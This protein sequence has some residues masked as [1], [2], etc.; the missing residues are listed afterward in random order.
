MNRAKGLLAAGT[1]TGVI[2]ITVLVFG[3]GSL[4]AQPDDAQANPDTAAPAVVLP[5]DATTAT[6]TQANAQELQD[7][8]AY[9]Q[10][11]EAALQIMQEREAVYQAQIEQ[12]N[13]TVLQLQDQLNA[14]MQMQPSIIV[15]QAAPGSAVNNHERSEHESHEGF[16]FDDD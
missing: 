15:G 12:A 7:L 16:E 11:L 5:A 1:L 13:R 4:K 9:N 6:T 14:Q 8:R 3:F 10:Q 2:L